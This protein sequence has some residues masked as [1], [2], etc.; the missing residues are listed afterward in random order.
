LVG[1]EFKMRKQIF[2]AVIFASILLF[3]TVVIA[4]PKE[5]P[6]GQPKEKNAPGQWKKT[7]EYAASQRDFVY[8]VHM[9]IWERMQAR[10]QVYIDMS[11][12]KSVPNPI[13]LLKLLNLISMES[14]EEETEPEDDP[15]AE[16]ELEPVEESE[17]EDET[18]PEEE[19]EPEDDPEAEEE[20]ET[21]PE[22]EPEEEE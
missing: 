10:N 9:R 18:E 14:E 15:E 21:E 13:G 17:P 1:D 7:N 8:A 20:E 16:E 6:P 4:T 19:T 22:E 12:L 2:Y 5:T 11:S 3:S